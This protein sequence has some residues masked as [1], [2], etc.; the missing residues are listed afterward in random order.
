MTEPRMD[1]A[2]Y[3]ARRVAEYD[4]IYDKPERRSDL[5]ALRAL[6]CRQLA[7]HD[8]LEIACGT[9]YW[10]EPISRTARSVLAT[11]IIDEA[12][13]RAQAREYPN[14]R[15]KF[16]KADAYTLAQIP[17]DFTAAFVGFWWSHVERQRIPEFISSLHAKLQPDALVV[18][19]DNLYVE[20]SSAPI[21]R[22]DVYGNT[23]QRRTL[24]DGSTHEII[25]NFPSESDLRDVLHGVA[26]DMRYT[27][28]HYYWCLTYRVSVI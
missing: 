14:G 12:L 27:A 20:G 2:A 22:K 13:E 3:Y 18:L 26:H 17:A 21:A 1:L 15:V 11:D 5:E 23:F 19:A 6:F 16:A 28:L 9:G 4:R 10:T 7:G 24:E 25:K 8:V